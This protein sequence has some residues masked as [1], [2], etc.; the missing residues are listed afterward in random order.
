MN[1]FRLFTGAA[2]CVVLFAT[3]S[4]SQDRSPDAHIMIND[5]ALLSKQQAQAVYGELKS[6][7]ADSYALSQ[8]E[9]ISDYQSWP[10][11]NNSPY[12]SATHGNRYVNN[13]INSEGATYASLQPGEK[14]PAGAMLLK[15]SFTVTN[16]GRTYPGA[17]FGME[18]LAEGT[19]P[20]TADWR[21]FM[22][23][24]D[25]SLFGDTTGANAH[26]MTYCHECHEAVAD[27]DFTF[28]IP[29]DF[30]ATD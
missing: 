12:I 29:E 18:K 6:R 27:R 25:G 15:D 23:I 11:V 28:Y 22:V 30:R 16:E 4:F 7:M 24:P 21:Y 14:L 19:N 26:L 17:L 1:W 13:Y 2:I 5:P 10:R 3:S 8:L 20:D 9:E